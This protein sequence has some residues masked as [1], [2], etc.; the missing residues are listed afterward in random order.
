MPAW[1]DGYVPGHGDKDADVMAVGEAPGKDERREG[2]PFVGKSGSLFTDYLRNVGLTRPDDVFMTN[3]A[4]HQPKGNDFEKLL[5]TRILKEGLSELKREIRQVDPNLIIAAGSWPL[6]YLTGKTSPAGT[7]G[8]GITSWR[9]SVLP[10]TL[11]E[12]YKVLPVYHPAAVLRQWT[13]HAVFSYD[14]EY[15]A[16]Q[17]EFPEIRRPAYEVHIDP[18][19]SEARELVAEMHDSDWLCVDIETFDDNTISC[20]GFADSPHRA[21]VIT[22]D[23]RSGWQFAQE[24][25][26]SPARK[27]LQF[28]TYD[29]I[30]M[31]RF[32]DFETSTY[33]VE[34]AEWNEGPVEI[35]SVGWD[36]LI[37]SATLMPGFP[38]GL[39]FLASVYTDFPY[40]KEDR[41]QWKED[42]DLD[43]LWHYNAKD[44]VAQ[45]TV[46]AKQAQEMKEMAD[47]DSNDW[48]WPED[49]PMPQ[50]PDEDKFI[51]VDP[52]DAIG[53]DFT[54]SEVRSA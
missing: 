51:S 43:T 12:G 46:T 3:L 21:L 5:G 22:F 48:T 19:E 27:T 52:A 33:R 7:K 35:E 13:W 31:E 15:A 49:F 39:D 23:M 38:S 8:A 45:Y 9:G 40:Y 20:I 2:R 34:H 28:G 6:Y 37:A 47:E 30:F 29:T 53:A 36:T 4:R 10:C 54:L 44:V 25:L 50:L 32:Y 18:P 42:Q 1:N 14:L 24:L 41:K 16:E 26:Q 17:A 11:V